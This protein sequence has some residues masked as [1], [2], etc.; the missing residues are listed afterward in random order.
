MANRRPALGVIAFAHLCELLNA[1]APHSQAWFREQIGVGTNTMTKFM[2][3]LKNRKLIHVAAWT[4]DG[5]RISTRIALWTWGY[6]Q[7]DADRPPC[8]PREVVNR[9][10]KRRRALAKKG[11]R[12]A[13]LQ[14]SVQ[15]RA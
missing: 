1:K 12:N 13:V 8:V 14:T 4:H 7:P 10:S 3:V 15:A 2:R 9:N 5:K 11:V 6:N